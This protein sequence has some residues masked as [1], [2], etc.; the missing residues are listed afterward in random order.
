MKYV[1][2]LGANLGNREE[3]IKNAIRLIAKRIGPVLKTSSLRESAALKLSGDTAEQPNY[4]NGA[5]VCESMHEP[6]AV[7]REL[8]AIEKDLGRVRG[9]TDKRWQ[10]RTI[11]LDLIAADNMVINL[12]ELIV[13]HA[14]MHRRDFVLLPL[15]EVWPAWCHPVLKKTVEELLSACSLVT[16]DDCE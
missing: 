5:I 10:P 3:N 7:L 4:I 8:L 2:A 13:P 6:L 12:P 14:E 1:V 9:V 15:S 11:D 16:S